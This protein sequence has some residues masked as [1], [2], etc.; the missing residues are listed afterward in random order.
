VQIAFVNFSREIP[1]FSIYERCGTDEVCIK[2]CRSLKAN[3]GE[4][5]PAIEVC[6][7]Q[8]NWFR[9]NRGPRRCSGDL[10]PDAILLHRDLV[11]LDIV[12]FE[13]ASLLV[14]PEIDVVIL[15]LAAGLA[16]VGAYEIFP[17][18]FQVPHRLMDLDEVERQ[19]LA[20][21]VI[22]DVEMAFLVLMGGDV[23]VDRAIEAVRL[24][25]TSR[26]LFAVPPQ[27]GLGPAS[28]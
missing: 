15:V 14:H 17:L 22:L 8:I 16:E 9:R 2:D 5:A 6:T 25:P 26:S 18:L 3:G 24:V 19:R 28:L 4:R 10:R 27:P 11:H 7:A 21:L 13:L 23:A 1:I 12:D 20:G